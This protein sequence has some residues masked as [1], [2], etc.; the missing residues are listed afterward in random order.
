MHDHV[1]NGKADNYD[2]PKEI[3]R[4]ELAAHQEAVKL[5]QDRPPF[6]QNSH[7]N[8][9]T[10]KGLYFNF[11]TIVHPKQESYIT[12]ELREKP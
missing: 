10:K 2:R 3:L 11:G 5:G 9:G 8:R 7:P 4:E 1:Y 12:A 6:S